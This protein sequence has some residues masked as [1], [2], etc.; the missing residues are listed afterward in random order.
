MK[1]EI[2]NKYKQY[3]RVLISYND[4]KQAN[5]IAN[6]ILSE[7]YYEKYFVSD[8]TYD[9]KHAY[10]NKILG[11]ALNCAMI[12]AYCRPYSGNDKK[13]NYKI[14]DLPK[15][16]LKG[17]SKEERRIHD[18]IFDERNKILAHSDSSEWEMN[19][20]FLK[21]ENQER[22]I[23]IPASRD[24]RAPLLPKIVEIISAI[25]EKMMDRLMI[26][27]DFIEKE[28]EGLLP[29]KE[30]SASKLKETAKKVGIDVDNL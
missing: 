19:P 11:E 27:R 4:Y 29:T 21:F 26:E 1:V 25:S 22:K 5:E 16:L 7:K 10:K 28:L 3:V 9:E 13:N 18:L 14:P 8:D 24:V 2:D 15:K 12:I 30:I 23:L 17:F 6:L 20:Y